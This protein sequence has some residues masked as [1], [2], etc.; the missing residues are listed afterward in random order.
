MSKQ[1]LLY[2]VMESATH[3]DFSRVYAKLDIEE[4]RFNSHRRAISKM[5][6]KPPEFVVAEFFYG[7]SNNYAGVNVSNLDVLMYSL[8]KYAPQVKMIVL[9][10]KSEV[11]HVSKLEHILP[12]HAVLIQPVTSTAMAEA[13]QSDHK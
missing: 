4:L 11:E 9:V 6:T 5:K 7:Y 12:L 8:Q 2:S 10:D 13:L 1:P 3:P